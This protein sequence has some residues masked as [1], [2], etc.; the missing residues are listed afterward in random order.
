MDFY[1]GDDRIP[2]DGVICSQGFTAKPPSPTMNGDQARLYLAQQFMNGSQRLTCQDV[3]MTWRQQT[4][5]GLVAT[6]QHQEG[7][8]AGKN[9]F[10]KITIPDTELMA[11][12]LNNKGHR[13]RQIAVAEVGTT[14]K[15]CLIHNSTTYET[16]TL[17]AL[18][19]PVSTRE[20]TFLTAIPSQYI[21]GTRTGKD[22]LNENMPFAPFINP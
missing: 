21:V 10:Y 1:R 7:A 17:I 20:A 14:R 15:Y 5:G 9:Y 3:G 6:A 2:T 4:P 22:T 8:Y 18:C 12:E 16:A 13:E 19:H 11:W